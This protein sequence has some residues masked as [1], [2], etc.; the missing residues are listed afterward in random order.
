MN[1][2]LYEKALIYDKR[3]FFQYYWSLL[4]TKHLLLFAIIPSNDYNSQI[5]KICI[6]MFSFSQIYAVN[7]L[8]F[9]ENTFHFIYKDGGSFD[10][11]Y[12]LPQIIYSSLISSVIDIIIRTLSLSAKTILQ[13]KKDI[14][15]Q[16]TH[17]EVKGV[18]RFLLIKFIF[19]FYYLLFISYFFLVLFSII[20]C[21]I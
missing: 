10:F 14:M 3:S 19:F 16:K 21:R 20:W 11:I 13:L 5:I 8:F 9:S 2:L 7:A 4:R 1:S 17:I 6:F 18:I 15:T 12:N